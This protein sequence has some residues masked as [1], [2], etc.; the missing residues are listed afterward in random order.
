MTKVTYLYHGEEKEID[1]DPRLSVSKNAVKN[2]LKFTDKETCKG[3]GECGLCQVKVLKGNQT[4]KTPEEI[5]ILGNENSRIRLGCKIFPVEGMI[6]EIPMPDGIFLT[7]LD[8][9]LKSHYQ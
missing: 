4:A 7:D 1:A 3:K 2:Y 8:A 5:H 9:E 6:V